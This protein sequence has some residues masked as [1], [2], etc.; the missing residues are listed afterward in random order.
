MTLDISWNH[1]QP[2]L[3]HSKNYQNSLKNLP[4]YIK[5]SEQPGVSRH[6][7]FVLAAGGRPS[8]RSPPGR[9]VEHDFQRLV[10]RESFYINFEAF[11]M[12]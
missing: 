7:Y 2:I 3:K 1:L 5:S 8:T 6:E 4:K 9:L 10:M 11:I 12:I